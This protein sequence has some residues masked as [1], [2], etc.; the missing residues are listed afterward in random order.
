[1][2][3]PDPSKKPLTFADQ[4]RLLT[5][6]RKL[7]QVRKRVLFQQN[8]KELERYIRN[9][10]RTAKRRGKASKRRGPWETSW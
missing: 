10:Q 6:R 8:P 9:A 1:M 2:T 4:L 5:K 7:E 3:D